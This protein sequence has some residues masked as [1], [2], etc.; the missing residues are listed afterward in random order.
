MLLH[1]AKDVQLCCTPINNLYTYLHT[2]VI[3]LLYVG[4]KSSWGLGGGSNGTRYGFALLL[5]TYRHLLQGGRPVSIVWFDFCIVTAPRY[6]YII[7]IIIIRINIIIII[8]AHA[9]QTTPSSHRGGRL[10]LD[11]SVPATGPNQQISENVQKHTFRYI[12]WYEYDLRQ[13]TSW[14][15]SVLYVVLVFRNIIIILEIRG[16]V[17]SI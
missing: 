11:T 1:R 10:Y 15:R 7:I 12:H 9:L 14:F 4:K 5:P 17:D 16:P 3:L 13:V 8:H 2:I 6:T